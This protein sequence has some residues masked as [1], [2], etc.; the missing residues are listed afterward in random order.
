MREE[1]KFEMPNIAIEPIDCKQFMV[2][3]PDKFV[4]S[5]KKISAKSKDRKRKK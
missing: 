2:S 5:H 4:I 1:P 3:A